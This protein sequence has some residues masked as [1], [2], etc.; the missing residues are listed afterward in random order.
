MTV[1][2]LLP[3]APFTVVNLAAGA[4]EI[5][6]RNFLLGSLLGMAPGVALMTVFGDRLGT[7]LRRPD[8][9]NLAIVAVI[10]L[11]ALALTWALRRWSRR[12]MS[13]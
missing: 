11:L 12:R 6:T 13:A 10:A 8:L 7:W 1:L 4:S 5:R 3:V 2:R 9:P